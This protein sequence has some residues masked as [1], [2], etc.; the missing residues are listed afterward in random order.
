MERRGEKL[1]I[2]QA[3]KTFVLMCVHLCEYYLHP[4][5]TVDETVNLS[6]SHHTPTLLREEAEIRKSESKEM[7]KMSA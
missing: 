3:T 4:S 1:S 5:S 2:R 6:E 7:I